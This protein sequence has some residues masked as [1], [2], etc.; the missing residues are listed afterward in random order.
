MPGPQRVEGVHPCQAHPSAAV[1]PYTQGLFRPF[2]ETISGARSPAARLR[3]AAV[4]IAKGAGLQSPYEPGAAL[5]R[6][7]GG[8][9][10]IGGG[11]AEFA[12]TR[13][14]ART[15]E[16]ERPGPSIAGRACTVN[17]HP[18]PFHRCITEAR[19]L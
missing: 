7:A 8:M 4:L 3:S 16:G 19:S 2:E 9:I 11:I 17:V 15:E 6:V 10:R 18:A 12:C 1:D 13:I 14:R 5:T